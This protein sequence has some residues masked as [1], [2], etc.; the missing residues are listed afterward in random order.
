MT[1][2]ADDG[3]GG[4]ATVAVAIA[5]TDVD[6]P[7]LA[8]DAP[9]VTATGRHDDEPG[10]ELGG[11]VERGPAGDPA[12]PRAPTMRAAPLKVAATTCNTE[13]AGGGRG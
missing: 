6:E 8:P 10:R 4:T 7:P 13:G 2:K 5:L 11:A 9:G 3:K 1:V 12:Y